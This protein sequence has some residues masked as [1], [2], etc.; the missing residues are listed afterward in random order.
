MTAE[1]VWN[2]IPPQHWRPQ[3][4]PLKD[5]TPIPEPEPPMT[6]PGYE[7]IGGDEFFR[8]NVG[9]PLEADMAMVG[10]P[11]NAGSSAR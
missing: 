3:N 10:Q 9:V 6:I 2:E 7:E 1:P 5:S 4:P 11:L 8:V